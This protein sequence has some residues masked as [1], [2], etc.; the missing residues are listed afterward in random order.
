MTVLVFLVGTAFGVLG[1][2]ALVCMARPRR[3][4]LDLPKSRD[5]RSQ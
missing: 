3:R 2:C 1:T 4:G 5:R